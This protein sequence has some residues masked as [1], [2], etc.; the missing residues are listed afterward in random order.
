MT[1][2]F[3]KKFV[4]VCIVVSF[5]LCRYAYAYLP[6]DQFYHE[7]WYLDKI[8]APQAWDLTR[9]SSQDIIIAILDTGVEINHPDLKKNIWLNADEIRGDGIDNDNNG[10]IDDV[11]GWDFVRNIPDP[12][13]KFDEPY[14]ENGI[15]H[16]TLVAG[17]AAAIGDNFEGISGLA[18][19]SRIMPLRVLNS[20]GTGSVEH[21]I[22]AVKY[23]VDN[24]AKI[25]N[26]SFVGTDKNY[27]LKQALQQAWERGV[28]I[29]AA[30][31]NE[32]AGQPV[33]LDKSPNYPICL[34]EDDYN[35]IIGVAAV[36]NTDRKALFSD[37]GSTC[38]DI[39]APGTRIYGSLVYNPDDQDYQEYYG[40]YWS[41]TSIAA[42]IIS[43]LSA[44]VFS[45]NP[46]F[47]NKQ[48]Q[49]FI[50][51][52]ADEIDSINSDFVGQL[53][54]GRV[55]AYKTVV[56]S[57]N[58]LG[59]LPQSHY[60]ITGAGAGGGPHV[61]VFDSVGL[62]VSGFFAYDKKFTGGVNVAAGDVDGDGKDEIITGAG[63]GGGPHIRVFDLFGQPKAGFFAYDKKFTGGVN[64]A[65][66]DVDGDGKDE[67][68]VG[69]GAGGG[70]HVQV[71]DLFGQPKA[72]FFA[73]DKKFTGG[74]NVAAGDVDG[75]GKDEIITGAGAG[76]GPHIRVFDGKG[77]L[78]F[79]F[80]AFNKDFLGGVNVAA[81]DVDG[82]GKDEIM[83]SVASNAS[84]YIRVFD[85]EFLLLRLQFLA[86]DRDFYYG[87]KIGVA[88]FDG[89]HQVEIVVAPSRDKES[90]VEIFNFQGNQL[91]EFYAYARH[92]QGGVNVA[93]M[94]TNGY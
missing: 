67:I 59:G 29:V 76:G 28:I 85:P 11:N 64:V 13:P 66:G 93:T 53:G 46:L 51:S 20:E 61:R 74:V 21:V 60:I 56:Y 55:N 10:Y 80:F 45:I 33:N 44:L 3:R 69:S 17:I 81:G 94:K 62:P 30:A 14:N 31:G 89:N 91:S 40:G 37:Y 18:W 35:F 1:I 9:E 32:T 2:F 92:F 41:G 34:D 5:L 88:D 70:P 47:S 87:A 68:I 72:G 16:G 36:D 23:A 7:Q 65:A 71:F 58:Q 39:S 86:Y 63:A 43:G 73:Y 52:Q 75:D 83:V 24:G 26:L 25:I 78:K 48:V 12:R 50:L 4:F 79:H 84:S 77:G 22:A 8:K 49:D 42:P 54:A 27:F 82:D 90:Q 38:V 6:N 57:Y 15:H 19:Q